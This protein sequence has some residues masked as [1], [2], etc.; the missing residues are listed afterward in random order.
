[1]PPLQRGP[2]RVVILVDTS[3]AMA[4]RWHELAHQFIPTL[5]DS[6]PNAK[7][8]ASDVRPTFFTRVMLA[9]YVYHC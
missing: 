7:E 1:M 9:N 4:P 3:K 2:C 6:L 5:L 8:D